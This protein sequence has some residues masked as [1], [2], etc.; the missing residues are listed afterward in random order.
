MSNGTLVE[1][2]QG[3]NLEHPFLLQANASLAECESVTYRV[4]CNSV[5]PVPVA[6]GYGSRTLTYSAAH[7]LKSSKDHTPTPF[8]ETEDSVISL[9][10]FTGSDLHL[11]K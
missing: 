2:G 6:S 8:Q 3:G 4:D 11:G 10:C 9:T 1:R 7:M 5:G